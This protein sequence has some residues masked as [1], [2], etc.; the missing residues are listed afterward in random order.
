MNKQEIRRNT[1]HTHHNE[2]N[3]EPKVHGNDRGYHAQHVF[4]QSHGGKANPVGQPLRIVATA[5]IAAAAATSAATVHALKGHVGG[6]DKAHEVDQ[7]LGAANQR[8]QSHQYRAGRDEEPRGRVARSVFQFLENGV[9]A[10]T[11]V[12]EFDGVRNREK[13]NTTA[14]TKSME[15]TRGNE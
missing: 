13:R 11:Y 12:R 6:V 7:Q 2:T 5:S 15:A 1:I 14:R 10:R 4:C 3:L 9:C 8:E